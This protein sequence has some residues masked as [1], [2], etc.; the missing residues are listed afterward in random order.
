MPTTHI[1]KLPLGLV[2]NRRADLSQSVPLEWLS[3]QVA[4]ELGLPV[5]NV[6]IGQFED[7]TALSV[8][9]FDR[10]LSAHKTWWQRIPQEDFCQALGLSPAHK[11][12]ADGGTG[13]RSIMDVLLGSEN[14]EADR[15]VFFTTQILFWLMAATDGHAKNFSLHVRAGGSYRLAPLYDIFSTYPIQGKGP[16]RLDAHKAKL[17]MAVAGRNR[18]Y[19][20]RDIRR[21]QWVALSEKPARWRTAHR[22]AERSDP[23]RAGSH[24]QSSAAEF[25]RGCIRRHEPRH[26]RCRQTYRQR[27]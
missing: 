22:I 24:R 6:E 18:D 16:N 26:A 4:R 15:R 10:Q 14:A 7:Q 23:T 21:W 17:A 2:G 27:A 1:F 20:I 8:K 11:Y 5:A 13:I 9:R 25:P 3:M 19:L 12:E